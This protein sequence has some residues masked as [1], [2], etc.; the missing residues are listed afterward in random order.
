[1]NQI[2]EKY[3]ITYL[4]L[5]KA[6]KELNIPT[7]PSGYWSKIRNDKKVKQPPLPD[8]D[9]TS[10]EISK[11]DIND[12]DLR[13][14][15][16][17]KVKPI[18]VKKTLYNP[19]PLIKKTYN[20]LKEGD[21]NQ[22]NRVQVYGSNYLDVLV[23][24][25]SV[26]RAMRILDALVKELNRQGIKVETEK[27]NRSA[28]S[29]V[30]IGKEKIYLQMREGGYRKKKERD[31]SKRWYS[32]QYEYC[33]NGKLKLSLCSSSYRSPD[34]TIK[35]W[36]NKKLEERMDEFFPTLFE[37]AEKMKVSREK[38]EEE[39]RIREKQR[40]LR[41]EAEQQKSKELEQLK[42]L[43]EHASSF[44]KAQYIYD[45]INKVEE[46]VSKLEL[47]KQEKLKVKAWLHWATNHADRLNPVKK[48]IKSI[49]E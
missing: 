13:Q 6:C 24:P 34:K 8:F 28:K 2:Q 20:A 40:Q 47:N 37:L 5:K 7:P 9:R 35:D 1:M 43:E 12:I 44:T 15:L 26:K 49:F 10:I 42:L 18:V 17:K 29:F 25:D 48:T 16:P 33:T 30:R 27:V 11:E 46:E 39:D 4:K 38:E 45:L 14:K 19:H 32:S 3:G 22:F 21:L 23:G 41:A 31:P 36:K